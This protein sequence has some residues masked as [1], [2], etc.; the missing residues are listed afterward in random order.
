[1]SREN[2]TQKKGVED[3]A[4]HA[5]ARGVRAWLNWLVQ[6]GDLATSMARV[7]MPKLEGRIPAPS[8]PDEARRRLAACDRKTPTG[9]RNYAVVLALPAAAQAAAKG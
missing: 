5:H 1:M 9:A 7:T 3:T 6:E 4:Q 2:L 8:T